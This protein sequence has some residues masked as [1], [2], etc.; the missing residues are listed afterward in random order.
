MASS[1]SFRQRTQEPEV[2]AES[3]ELK[4]TG[5]FTVSETP[6]S[7]YS[8]ETES[9]VHAD[10]ALW[11][12]TE[13]DLRDMKR[14][15]KKQ[16][17]ERNFS[18]WSALGFVSVYMATWEFVL[19]SLSV[20]F[21]N[22]GFAGLFWCF[23]TTV[24]CYSTI[25]ASLAEMASMAPTSGGQYHWVS[26]FAP[27]EY[28]RI[29]SY[30][31][32]WMSTLGWLA[33]VAGSNFVLTT[34]IEAMVEITRPEFVFENWQYVLLMVAFVVITILFNTWGAKA[35]PALET[36][37]LVGHLAGFFIVLIPLWVLCPKNSASEVFSSFEW[38]GG[39]SPGPGYLVSQVKVMYCN[40]GSD[41]VV[42]ISEE[43]EDASITV[44]RCMW[45]SYIG[46]VLM[47]IVMLVTMLFCIGPLEDVIDSDVPYLLLFN[48][49]GS[50]TLSVVLNVI[51]FVLIYAGNITALA[52]CAREM[53]AFARDR[54]LPFSSWIGKM[55]THWNIPFHSVYATSAACILLSFIN[56]GSTLAF[57]IVV[58]V[59]L[60]GLLST[61]MISIGCVLR[62]RIRGEPLPPARWSLGRYG[63]LVNAFGFVYSGVIIVFSC[64]PS[65]LPVD[66]AS[67]NYGPL[68][69]VAVM[70]IA[71]AVYVV[72]GK[73]HYTAPVQ[74]VEGRKAAGIE[75]QSS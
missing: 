2:M 38:K 44:P 4:G 24:V 8:P 48:N 45:Y 42:H 30:A 75:L 9:A 74:F 71:V 69:W 66:A 27:P 53:W 14:L 13:H 22:G 29:L 63:I 6:G 32:G 65:Y 23:L 15:G 20:G 43:V 5:T 39:W 36:T 37:S 64:F 52:T 33:S 34:Q 56:F 73:R 57:N 55:N 28:Q 1:S 3:I 10:V 17:F 18:F 46:N 61:Y 72:H 12:E 58:S 59:S 7:M 47:G 40:L 67:A 68:I 21:A 35:L 31:S 41:S 16:E 50:T 26:E 19:V 62:K 25:V 51:L 11:G 49:T 70:V 54:G 60:L